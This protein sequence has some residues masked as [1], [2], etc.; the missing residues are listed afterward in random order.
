MNKR[1]ERIPEEAMIAG[2][3]AGLAR[4]FN[5]DPTLIRVL[6]VVG[7]FLPHFPS[8]LIYIIL[9]IALP[10][11]TLGTVGRYESEPLTKRSLTMNPY[12]PSNNAN[13]SGN[14][15]GGIV[16]ILLGVFFML[17]QWFDIDFGKLWPLILIVVGV[18]IIFKD[19][20]RRNDQSYNQDEPPYNSGSNLYDT[21]N[22]PTN[23]NNPL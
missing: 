14:I 21:N 9:W 1:L 10:E 15:I 4:Y 8:I 3:S 16:L 20:I 13:T 23:P 12:P 5:V 18:W 6:F 11:R 22:D 2:V 19:R 17:K 7:I